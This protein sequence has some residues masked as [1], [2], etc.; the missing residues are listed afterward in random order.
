MI[1]SF[2]Y[3]YGPVYSWRLG[4]SLG[5]DP[6]A[7]TDKICNMNCS[8]CQLGVTQELS[9]E[10]RN[11]VN[12]D[13]IVEE[14]KRIPVHFIDYLTIS[15]RG[16]PTLAKNLGLMIKAI[17]KVRREKVAVITNGLLLTDPAVRSDVMLADCVLVKL[18]AADQETFEAVDGV[19]LRF[20]E[21]VDGIA[22][23]RRE[24]KGKL[25]LQIMLL[26]NNFDNL[27]EI[28]C[29]ARAI[30]PDEIQ[31]NTPTRPCAQKPIERVQMD[32]AKKFFWDMP[33]VSVFDQ[34]QKPYTPID[35][36][37]TKARHG[38]YRKTRYF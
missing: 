8:Y 26:D 14:L 5:I 13:E 31:L 32:F 3:V 21:V 2:K 29:L 25:A 38:N 15:G 33:V 30:N 22:Q 11:Y 28:A 12:V 37:A 20:D 23:F 4:R 17:K 19:N 7:C 35:E 10:R 24:F 27:D 34:E 18:D 1:N 36:K 6:L 9:H 16:E